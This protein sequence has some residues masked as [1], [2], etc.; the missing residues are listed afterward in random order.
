MKDVQI[1]EHK[2]NSFFHLVCQTS[3]AKDLLLKNQLDNVN[4]PIIALPIIKE[5]L[6]SR[7]LTTVG[8]LDF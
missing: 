7:K 3:K 8:L 4:F 6:K 1:V 2:D 5:H